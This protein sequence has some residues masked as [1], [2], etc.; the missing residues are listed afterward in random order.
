[1]DKTQVDESVISGIHTENGV[2]KCM[3]KCPHC[4]KIVPCS[5]AANSL[6]NWLC[7]NYQAH[8]KSHYQTLDYVL[9]ENNQLIECTQTP[10]KQIT[11]YA[12]GNTD[13]QKLLGITSPAVM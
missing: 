12:N 13:L 4:K 5:L 1:M 6:K 3:I 11:S 2:S 7:G 8:L 9:D 10:N